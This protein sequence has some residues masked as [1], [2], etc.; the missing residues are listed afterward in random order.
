[1]N[2]VAP[3]LS[4]QYLRSRIGKVCVAILGSTPAEMIEKAEAAIRENPFVEFRLDYLEKPL[5]ALPKLKTF[6]SERS[7]VTAIGTCRRVAG[8]GK[9]KGKIADELEI[10]QK[11][12]S[13]GFHMVDIELQTAE[14]IKAAELEKLRARGAALII[15]YHDF[16]ATKDLDGIFERVEAS[17]A[18]V[19]QEPTVQHWGD[20]D[21]A[22]RDPAGNLVRIQE[23]R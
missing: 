18:E 5:A 20:R 11:A 1:M 22:F 7:E 4:P 9:F 23:L 2:H 10:L 15:S 6:L 13:S 12:A 17:G 16:A 14:A 19:V 8:G 3:A 21:C